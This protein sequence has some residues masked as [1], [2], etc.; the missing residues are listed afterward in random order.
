VKLVKYEIKRL[1]WYLECECGGEYYP[2]GNRL[3]SFRSLKHKCNKCSKIIRTK[4]EFPQLAY[5]QRK[6]KTKKIIDEDFKG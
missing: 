4:Y 1:A 6:P 3:F 2:I 5:Y